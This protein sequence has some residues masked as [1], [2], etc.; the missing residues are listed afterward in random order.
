VQSGKEEKFTALAVDI[1]ASL[2]GQGQAINPAAF[3]QDLCGADGKLSVEKVADAI[4]KLIGPLAQG[5]GGGGGGGGGGGVQQLQQGRPQSPQF[6]NNATSQFV[7]NSN[8]RAGGQSLFPSA[9]PSAISSTAQVAW[10]QHMQRQQQQ[11]QF[12]QHQQQRQRELQQIDLLRSQLQHQHQHNQMH[13]HQQ[14]QQQQQQQQRRVQPRQPPPTFFSG[15]AAA[16]KPTNPQI[17]THPGSPPAQQPL[18]EDPVEILK[19]AIDVLHRIPTLPL[20]KQAGAKIAVL[21]AIDQVKSYGAEHLIPEQLMNLLKEDGLGGFSGAGAA[22]APAAAAANAEMLKA[23][24][25]SVIA[26]VKE[27]IPNT[28]TNATTPDATAPAAEKKEAKESEKKE[29][30]QE[31]LSIAAAAA[32]AAMA[33]TSPSS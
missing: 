29:E 20:G 33:V 2:P 32:A 3:P 4:K 16:P 28:G 15:A 1:I 31:E 10:N 26:P 8:G 22:P 5:Q 17:A 9:S 30:P 25:D 13:Q 21:Q 14:Q 23:A 7:I 24:L 27:S 6:S 12:Q 11:H 18:P 19:I